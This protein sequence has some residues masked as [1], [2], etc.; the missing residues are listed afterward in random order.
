MHDS[1]ARRN[2]GFK[3]HLRKRAVRQALDNRYMNGSPLPP[4][5]HVVRVTCDKRIDKRCAYVFVCNTTADL[6]DDTLD[7]CTYANPT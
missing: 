4:R 3:T 6:R 7:V 1:L 5:L 2:A